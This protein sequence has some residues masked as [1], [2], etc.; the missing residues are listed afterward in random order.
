MKLWTN[1]S[2][3]P[4]PHTLIFL[5]GFPFNHTMWDGQ[6]ALAR[7]Y[8]RVL[9][10]DQRGH[11][12]SEAGLGQFAFES[13]VDDLL[14]L[15]DQRKIQK[16]VLCGLS[17]GGYVALRTAERAPE[18]VSGL[19][20]CNT[21]SEADTQEAK[22]KR[23]V[24]VKT[25]QEKGISEFCEGFLKAALSPET[26]AAQP[27]LVEQVRHMIMG[28]SAEGMI[29]AVLAMAGRT[30][31]TQSLSRIKVPTLIIGGEKDP[32]I[33]LDAIQSLHQKIA[34]STMAII[35][36]AAHM[37]NLENP[38]VFNQHFQDFLKRII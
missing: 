35:P 23:A 12:Q 6:A 22:L 15:M 26:W 9:S 36:G 1:D 18:R 4:S 2:G 20:L 14:E 21:R 3:A 5:H 16:A 10:Y 30:D 25:I 34:G 29:G 28:G 19:I 27:A 17:M 32:I 13:F 33:P 7:P 11:G 31:T 24:T 38:N 8:F 37:S